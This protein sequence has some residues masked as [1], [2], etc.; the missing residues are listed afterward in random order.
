MSSGFVLK[1]G[2]VVSSDRWFQSDVRVR[3]SQIQ[4]VGSGLKVR[5]GETEIDCSGSFIYPG[6]INAHDHLE[7]NLFHRLGEPPYPN[8]YE[9]G[10][11]LH[12]R[13]KSNI[14][15]IQ[16]IPLRYRLWWGA[17]KNLFS[18]VTRVVHHNPYY[19][20]FR[21]AYPVDILKRY[22]FAHSLRF[23]PDLRGALSRRKPETPFIIHL[24]EGQDDESLREISELNDLGGI[25]ERTVAIHAVNIGDEDIELLTRRRASVVWCPS[26][27]SYLFGRTA[28]IHSL[29]G[30][31]PVALGTDS[32]LTG[33]VS[34]F[35]ELRTAHRL[36]SLSSDKLFGMVTTEPR[37]IFNFPFD[38]GSLV[39]RG[40]ADLFIVSTNNMDPYER[41]ICCNPGDIR[42]L[43]CK[44]RILI[45]D[46]SIAGQENGFAKHFLLSLNGR[47]KCIRSKAFPKLFRLLKPY[48]S[49][50]SFISDCRT[51]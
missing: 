2:A 12:R 6:L 49:H 5:R 51:H 22:T 16:G 30:R 33:S 44:G 21:F 31:V 9:W 32:S 47:E 23:D 50:Y 40:R 11:D 45:C 28:P 1:N 48:L 19:T 10:K 20:H 15:E 3:G 29:Y 41:L 24:A 39:E 8:A 27:N 38:A 37:S 17:W 18:G 7:F 4:E 36:S 42:L 43:M 26:S 35:E 34:L 13:W 46:R 25:D 14:A